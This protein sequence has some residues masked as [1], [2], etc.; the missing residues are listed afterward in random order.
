MKHALTKKSIIKHTLQVGG[1]TF[2]SRLLGLAREILQVKFLGV[3]V[4]ADAFTAAFF[5]PNSFRKIFAEGALT[6]AFFPTFIKV[7]KKEGIEKANG[8]MSL[9]FLC[10]EGVV[11][12]LCLFVMVF[13]VLTINLTFPGFSQEQ[14]AAAVP[15]LRILMPF[16]FFLSTSS[17]LTGALHSVHHFF[18]PAFASI[19]L[20]VFYVGGILLCLHYGWP[21]EYLCFAILASG[22]FQ[23][24]LHFIAY[25]SLGFTFSL[26]DKDALKHFGEVFLKFLPCFLAM[27][28]ME[29]NLFV[30]QRFASY[31]HE[32]S[33]KLIN[34]AN[35]FMGIPLGVFSV[36]FSTIL[37]PHFTRVSS[38]APR[39]LSFYLL[40]ST[41]FVF[42]VTIPATIMMSYLASDIFLT[43]FASSSSKKFPV[44]LISESGWILVGFLLGLFFF[45]LNKILLTLYYS[46]RDTLTPTYTAIAA[47]I[48][49]YGLNYVLVGRFGSFG[50]ALAT[51]ISGCI[52]M[53]LSLYL[54]CRLHK[55]KLYGHYFWNFAT[56]YIVQLIVVFIPFYGIYKGVRMAAEQVFSNHT[57]GFF[58]LQSFGYWIWAAPLMAACFYVLYVTRKMF[59]VKVYFL[60]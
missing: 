15:C 47:T 60:D 1:N 21:V 57:L 50:L 29:V 46:F 14:I 2:V 27:S 43:I 31:L 5:L 3:G 39:R 19:I 45:S 32:G 30:D 8:L 17:L 52:Q 12:L 23:C 11:F 4:V 26:P 40:E 9:S 53:L 6:A 55:F 10:F 56:R 49:N 28:V 22:F 59:K 7:Y 58:M 34:L 18:V 44:H 37:L 38:Y 36:A 51:S 35:R 13:P 42:W 24:L 20:N 33:V 16:I 41:K 25:F 48:I 54:L